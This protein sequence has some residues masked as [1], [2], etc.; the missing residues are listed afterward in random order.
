MYRTADVTRWSYT[1]LCH[2]PVPLPLSHRQHSSSL[3]HLCVSTGEVPATCSVYSINVLFQKEFE[4]N[5]GSGIIQQDTDADSQHTAATP[6]Q[7]IS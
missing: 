1:S 7:L 5:K 3:L 4:T 2:L 6:A